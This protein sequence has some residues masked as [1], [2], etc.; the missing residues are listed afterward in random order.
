LVEFNAIGVKEWLWAE[1][2]INEVQSELKHEEAL[3]L[4]TNVIGQWFLAVKTFRAMEDEIDVEHSK[5]PAEPTAKQESLLTTLIQ[6]GQAILKRPLPAETVLSVESTLSMLEHS[7]ERRNAW[8]AHRDDP[9]LATIEDFIFSR[10][11]A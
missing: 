8:I 11:A 2:L 5:S 1:R 6:I 10:G 3:G 7:R 4:F 9:A